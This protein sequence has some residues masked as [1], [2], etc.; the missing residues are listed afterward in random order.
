MLQRNL[1]L[2]LKKLLV[3][4]TKRLVSK[5]CLILYVIC[6]T[7][8]CTHLLL[9][10]SRS[11]YR[12]KRIAYAFVHHI[13]RALIHSIRSFSRIRVPFALSHVQRVHSYVL[14]IFTGHTRLVSYN[15]RDDSFFYDITESGDNYTES[16]LT[17]ACC[18]WI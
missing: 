16:A 13:L 8:I 9:I 12:Q 1:T 7:Y 17:L 10:V 15:L 11:I 3:S 14:S 2:L 6:Y 18:L 4:V 5:F